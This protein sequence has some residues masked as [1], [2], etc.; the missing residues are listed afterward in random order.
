MVHIGKKEL[1]R[2][3]LLN[4][5]EKITPLIVKEKDRIVPALVILALGIGIFTYYK[6]SA[7]GVRSDSQWQYLQALTLYAS[8]DTTRASE[9]F[10]NL[11]TRYKNQD[12]GKRAIYYLAYNALEKGDYG[13]AYKYFTAFTKSPPRDPFLI[14]LAYAGE[15]TC[16]YE[17]DKIGEASRKYL[18]AKEIVP[19][20]SY[21]AYYLYKAAQ[22]LKLDDKPKEA[23][24]LLQEFERDYKNHAFY[25]EVMAEIVYLQGVILNKG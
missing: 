8:H 15:A 25:Q 4:A 17:Q 12:A 5:L 23:L 7:K 16:L 21:K 2:D 20:K 19:F 6:I 9:L 3:P 24:K 11:A 18:K 14:A 10:Q 1:R 22:A 13:Q